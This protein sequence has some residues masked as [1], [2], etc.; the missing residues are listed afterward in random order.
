VLSAFKEF[1]AGVGR[2]HQ[3][4]RGW[5]AVLVLANLVLPLILIT[6]VEAQLALGAGMAGMV[7]ALAIVSRQGYTRLLGLMHIFWIPLVLYF[8][9]QLSQIPANDLFGVWV[10]SLICVNSISLVI[11]AV[12]VIRYVAGD[13]KVY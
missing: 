7:I 4:W 1:N 12:D 6:H 11:D 9:S 3:A 10:R 2:M 8:W 5:L 13:R